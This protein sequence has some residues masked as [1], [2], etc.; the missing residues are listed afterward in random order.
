MFFNY[1]IGT[2][3]SMTS[4]IDLFFGTTTTF[5]RPL[6]YGLLRRQKSHLRRAITTVSYRFTY[7]L[8]SERALKTQS[9]LGNSIPNVAVVW[10]GL[11][12]LRPLP[13]PPSP[14][15]FTLH[16]LSRLRATMFANIQL[17]K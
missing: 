14:L 13:T 3:P 12:A 17:V 10:W 8:W 7:V 2:F 5:L 9:G 11:K 4:I 1:E 15:S 6:F 16:V